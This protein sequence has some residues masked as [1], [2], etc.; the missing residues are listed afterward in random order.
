MRADLVVRLNDLRSSSLAGA[1]NDGVFII[2][3][4]N[5]AN[6]LFSSAYT[7]THVH[8]YSL[9]YCYARW[10]TQGGGEVRWQRSADKIS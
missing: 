10:R 5:S 1:D 7:H 8:T 4:S 3:S 6:S 2:I 9:H